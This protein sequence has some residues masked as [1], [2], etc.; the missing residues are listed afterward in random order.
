MKKKKPV[1]PPLHL[2]CG[3]H[4]PLVLPGYVLPCPIC[5]FWINDP[6]GIY[7]EKE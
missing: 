4:P 2:R 3:I 6:K 1:T 7:A 5:N